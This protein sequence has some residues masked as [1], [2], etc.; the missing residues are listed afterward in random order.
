TRRSA[1]FARAYADGTLSWARA[2]ALLPVVDHANA[3]AWVA[4]A[5][6]VTVRRL[7]DE[8]A[9]VLAARDTGLHASFDPPPLDSPLAFP[10]L[11]PAC[12]ARC[13]EMSPVQIGARGAGDD[14][15]GHE[16]ARN[17]AHS[18][19]LRS[20]LCDA[21]V[22]FSAPAS[23]VALFRDV[24]DAFALPETPRWVALERLL[25]HVVT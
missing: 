6:A 25:L 24:L 9:W 21:E 19:L 3:R 22:A 13:H 23:V 18:E 17:H 12:A 10:V 1:E 14:G 11:P 15:A 20:E 4:R 8:V 16:G 2:L 5:G 7:Y